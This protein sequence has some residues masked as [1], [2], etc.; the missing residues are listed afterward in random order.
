MDSFSF[1]GATVIDGSGAPSFVSDVLVR[2]DLIAK[3]GPSH[4]Q[5]ET[6]DARGLIL[7]PGFIDIHAHSEL[8]V[9]HDPT[10][11][12]KI[13]QGITSELSGNCGI[14]V[15][16]C[17]GTSSGVQKE[18]TEDVLGSWDAPYWKDLDAYLGEV[19]L[20]GCGTNMGLLTS[21]SALRTAVLGRD[22][23]RV[24]TGKEVEAMC[25]LL[26]ES[27][28]QGSYGFSTGLYYAPC[29]FAS[30]E[31]LVALL[32]MIR[33]YG[34]IFAVHHRC[35]GDDVIASLEE[36]LSLAKETG[37]RLEVSHLKAIGKD[38]QGKIG[39]MLTLLE[40]A[41]REGIDVYFDQYPY[42]YGSTSLFS[43]LPPAYLRLDRIS[44]SKA[45][46]DGQARADM[47][48]MM[49]HPDG[50]DSIMRMVGPQDITVL[51]LEGNPATE[52]RTI[53]SLAEEKGKDPYDELFDL[54]MDEKGLALM[55]DVTET[56]DSL[57]RIL[58][59]PLGCFGT[60]ALYAGA[61]HHP[62]SYSGGIRLLSRYGR[63]LHVLP[64]EELIRK[65]TGECARRLRLDDRGLV[66]EG[67]KAD[68]VLFDPNAIRDNGTMRDPDVLP[69]GLSLVMVNG[70]VAFR[71]GKPTG[72]VGGTILRS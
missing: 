60:D 40:N 68:L 2:D 28:R 52:M 26:E 70:T 5:G 12:A 22:P 9:L 21:H 71:D 16:P 25:A 24:A 35:E 61:L 51:V 18:L 72:S 19:S 3:I 11:R 53:A 23:N 57:M 8:E 15:F 42:A 1:R 17:R 45:L 66:R 63:E 7:C 31:E 50:W 6:I 54:L 59:S 36:V 27:F 49:L 62:R 4:D 13:Q 58:E 56:E 46:H 41:R 38:N 55:A 34:K 47:K 33:R 20:H 30:R 14:G 69:C 65:M 48:R 39:E 44:L 64:W 32:Y 37:V 29:M 43:L 67:M 10:M